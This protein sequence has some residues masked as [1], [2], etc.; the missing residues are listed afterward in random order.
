MPRRRAEFVLDL[1]Q[2]GVA[3]GGEGVLARPY[4]VDDFEA[5]IAAM[6]MDADKPAAWPQ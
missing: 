1:S 5:R 6:R 4:V 2:D 3:I